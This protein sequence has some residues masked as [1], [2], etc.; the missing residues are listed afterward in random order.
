MN[1]AIGELALTRI[2]IAHRPETIRSAER[3]IVLH[4][5]RIAEDMPIEALVARAASAD[6]AA[7]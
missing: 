6:N 3:V 2:V 4:G 7:P 5:G 1:R